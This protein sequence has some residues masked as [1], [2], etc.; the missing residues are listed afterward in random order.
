[1]NV[2]ISAAG[3][4]VRLVQL[5]KDALARLGLSSK[6]YACD[7]S[8][9]SAALYAADGHF[10]V[11]PACDSQHIPFLLGVCADRK[12]G[13]VVS[14]NDAELVHYAEARDRFEEQGTYIAIP[15]ADAVRVS[16]DKHKTHAWFLENDFPVPRRWSL[17]PLPPLAELPLPIIVKPARGSA[18]IGVQLVRKREDLEEALRATEDPV[19]EEWQTGREFTVNVLASRDGQLVGAVPHLRLEV[20]GGEVSKGR[21]FRHAG[22]DKLARRLVERL[23]GCRGPLNFQGFL[24]ATGDVRLTEINPRF[25]G[26]YPLAHAAGAPFTDWLLMEQL[27][28]PIPRGFAG[29]Q[30]D[31]VMM[32]Y[33]QEIVGRQVAPDR[34]KLL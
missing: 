29:W 6:V 13:L 31:I 19:I 12:I 26:G 20:R 17:D 4:R 34:I 11:P 28:R 8:P 7:S 32:R 25:G 14:V 30:S 21:T 15:H 27:G 1:M 2:L 24:D 33:D 3:R 10:L 22:L 5:F 16:R 23:P 18:G 9:L